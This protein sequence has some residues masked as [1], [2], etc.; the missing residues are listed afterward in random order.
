MF[1][2]G[3]TFDPKLIQLSTSEGTAAGAVIYAEIEGAGIDDQYTLVDGDSFEIC[4]TATMLAFTILECKTKSKEYATAATFGV[5]NVR[6]GATF[7]CAN[8]DTTA[9]QYTTL[10]T[11]TTPSYTTAVLSADTTTLTFTGVL[12]ATYGTGS[13]CEVEVL[14]IRA[15]SC[16]VD[17]AT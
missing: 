13:I 8:T 12:L 3:I 17:G 14:G 10:S 9:C 2:A 16:V 6:T 5:K 7:S 15:D 11:A 1:E 4:E